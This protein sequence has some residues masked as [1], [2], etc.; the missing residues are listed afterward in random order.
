MF[1]PRR[2][3]VCDRGLDRQVHD[4]ELKWICTQCAALITNAPATSVASF[5]HALALW[6]YDEASAPIVKAAKTAGGRALMNRLARPLSQLISP[7]LQDSTVLTWVPPSASGQ[8]RRGFDQGR[9]LTTKVGHLLQVPSAP[10]FTRAGR[11]QFGGSRTVRLQGPRL[12]I[13][14]D[15]IGRPATDQ[16]VVLDDV[17]TTGSSLST[18]AKALRSGSP[19]VD[20]VAVALAVNS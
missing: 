12:Q 3:P 14:P 7:Y 16:V 13:R 9:V 18:A 10:A 20:L 5:N 17:I 8:R 2:C 15:W 1:L 4:R 6:R 11:A 19:E